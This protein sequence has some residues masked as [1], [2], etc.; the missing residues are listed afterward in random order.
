MTDFALW[1]LNN[2]KVA[3]YQTNDGAER[4]GLDYT[5]ATFSYTPNAGDD[6]PGTPVQASWD[7]ETQGGILTGATDVAPAG[8]AVDAQYFLSI[9][10]VPGDSTASGHVHSI[11]AVSMSFGVSAGAVASSPSFAPLVVDA[12]ISEASPLLFQAVTLGTIYPTV[13]LTASKL[14]NG[15]LTTFAELS[16]SNVTV[17]SYQTIAGAERYVLDYTKADWSYLPQGSGG[18][19][20]SPVEES[21]DLAAQGGTLSQTT[22]LAAGPRRR[23]QYFLSIPG[24]PGDSTASG[25]VHAIAA[26]SMN[27]G[28]LAGAVAGDPEFGPLVVDATISQASPLLFAAAAAGTVYP[29]IEMTAAKLSAG[30]LVNFAE[31]MLGSV[32]IAE[33]S[34]QRRR[35]AICAELQHTR[36]EVS[37]FVTGWPVGSSR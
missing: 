25:H 17:A 31:L 35:R 8:P 13:S 32:T 10:G 11:D 12:S 18:Q 14:S 33:L 21:W 36:F 9:P 15:E 23:L 26:L 19:S 3:S 29:T 6:N 24:V 34:D 1:T 37:T 22:D 30:Q 2:V 28:V 5:K 16:L 4:Y 27:F 20:S 7:L